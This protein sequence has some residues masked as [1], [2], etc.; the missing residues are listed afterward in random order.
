MARTFDWCRLVRKHLFPSQHR[1]LD[2]WTYAHTLLSPK[3]AQMFHEQS[4]FSTS[5]LTCG[6]STHHYL[7]P[8]SRRLTVH[9]LFLKKCS[10]HCSS[11]SSV[12]SSKLKRSRDADHLAT[13]EDSCVQLHE[14]TWDLLA[15]WENGVTQAEESE[16][17]VDF[18]AYFHDWHKR[19]VDL[20]RPAGGKYPEISSEID[21]SA[22]GD[23]ETICTPDLVKSIKWCTFQARKS[24]HVHYLHWEGRIRCNSSIHRT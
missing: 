24:I 2:A 16:I 18:T 5:Q 3:D 21:R 20:M 14:A 12:W 4:N 10:S 7:T 17:Y 19:G 22:L 1:S 11:C 13:K 23:S 8:P 9:F 15:C 6:I